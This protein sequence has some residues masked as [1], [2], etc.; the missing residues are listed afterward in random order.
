MPSQ[1]GP[2]HSTPAT[3]FGNGQYPGVFSSE[4]RS[5][6]AQFWGVT[7]WEWP[8]PAEKSSSPWETQPVQERSVAG[9]FLVQLL[10]SVAPGMEHNSLGNDS[11]KATINQAGG[12]LRCQWHNGIAHGR[13]SCSE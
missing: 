10:V 13:S 7:G 8:S 4:N 5:V 3:Y 1:Y 6:Q 12:G 9:P 11:A 2:K